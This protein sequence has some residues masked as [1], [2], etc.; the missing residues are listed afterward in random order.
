MN[1]GMKRRMEAEGLPYGNRTHTYNSRLAQELAC[2]AGTGEGVDTIHD[3]LFRAY[4]VEGL[5]IAD[6]EV[7]TSVAASVGLPTGAA[8]EVLEERRFSDAV[9]ADW[10][11]SRSYGVTGVPTYA[12]LGEKLVGA[13]PFE[14]LVEFAKRSGAEPR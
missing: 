11:K 13:Q 6:T 5:N 7:L 14:S 1:A 8:R 4:F 12:V 3:A 10:E 9:D 2:W